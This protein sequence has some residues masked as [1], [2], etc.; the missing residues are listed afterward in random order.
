M[1]EAIAF[2]LVGFGV[3]VAVVLVGMVVPVTLEVNRLRSENA[4]LKTKLER[5]QGVRSPRT[6]DGA[7]HNGD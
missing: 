2:I 4:E 7:R 5:A 1:I 6:Q 3:G